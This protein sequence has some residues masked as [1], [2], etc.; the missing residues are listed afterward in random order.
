MSARSDAGPATW[1]S[2]VAALTRERALRHDDRRHANRVAFGP[3]PSREEL[4][5]LLDMGDHL[6][7]ADDAALVLSGAL[8]HTLV[9]VLRDLFDARNA[10]E[11][12][13]AG[14]CGPSH[15]PSIDKGTA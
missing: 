2:I 10:L 1:A 7:E 5:E 11:E 9:L 4:H 13:R 12:V 8:L 14:R 3:L 15:E 6:L